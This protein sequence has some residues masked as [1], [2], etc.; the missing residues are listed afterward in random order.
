MR[1]SVRRMLCA[2]AIAGGFTVLGI[3][4]ATSSAS[5]ADAPNATSGANGLV[6]GN[7]TGGH[8]TAPV[9]ASDNQVTVIGD[10]NKSGGST[11]QGGSGDSSSSSG[12]SSS[13]NSTSGAGGNGSGNQTDAGATAPVD[14][15]DNQVTVIGDGNTNGS[16]T[17]GDN[18]GS[19]SSGGDTTSGSPGNGSGNQTD[20]QVNAPVHATGNQITAIGDGEVTD[21]QPGDNGVDPTAGPGSGTTGSESS[22]G[23]DGANSTDGQDGTGSGNQTDAG[24]T[25]PVDASGNQVTVIG[26]GNDNTASGDNSGST[27]GTDGSDTTSGTDGN[28]SGNQTDADAIAPVDATGNQVTVIGNGNGSEN[29]STE[30]TSA[31]SGSDSTTGDD[32]TVAGNQAG[33]GAVVPVDAGGNQVTVIGDGNTSTGETTAG[34]SSAGNGAG[35][36][37]SGTDGNG[38]GNQ[39]DAG[40]AA[41]VN[42]TGNQ[43]TVIGDGNTADNTTTEGD[44]TGSGDGNTTDGENGNGSGN[45]TDPAAS[46][47]VDAGDN[48]VTVIGDG[49][50]SET[51][52]ETGT[53]GSGG[54]TTD[55]Q[56][57]TGSG[58]QTAPGVEAPV[59]S[60]ENQITIIGDGNSTERDNESNSAE[61]ETDSDVPGDDPAGDTGADSNGDSTASGTGCRRVRYCLR[62]C[63]GW[64]LGRCRCGPA[65]D[66]SGPRTVALGRFRTGHPDAGPGARRQPASSAGRDPCRTGGAPGQLTGDVVGQRTGQLAGLVIRRSAAPGTRTSLPRWVPGDRRNGGAGEN[67]GFP[68]RRT[69][70]PQVTRGSG[71]RSAAS[72]RMAGSGASVRD[73][74][75]R[76]RGAQGGEVAE[77]GDLGVEDLGTATARDHDHL[78]VAECA[79]GDEQ[80]GVRVGYV[81]PV[82]VLEVGGPADVVGYLGRGGRGSVQDLGGVALAAYADGPVHDERRRDQVDEGVASQVRCRGHRLDHLEVAGEVGAGAVPGDPE[83]LDTVER[84]TRRNDAV[85]HHAR[86]RIE[87]DVVDRTALGPALDDLDRVDVAPRGTDGRGQTTQRTGDVGQ[88]DAEQVRHVT[89]LTKGCFRVIAK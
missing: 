46:A 40:A 88:C 43:V 50:T 64:S 48:Q 15:T 21:V 14:A 3:A 20:A 86:V 55:G 65:A 76:D 33:L 75:A 85:G 74:S 42:A 83:D 61:E 11:D 72:G 6:S 67:H 49:N 31:G 26:N 73:R 80:V 35:N 37:T 66:R 9:D 8:A 45:Q 57:G 22:E 25:A 59:D 19:A 24:A 56:D 2:T 79:A 63:A 52:D 4:F 71:V 10:N 47:P 29:N 28:G 54:D 41:P 39:T 36:T 12:P 38:S 30:G 51:A 81:D 60:S 84:R 70:D 53:D 82:A 23:S 16:A 34:E 32:G 18:A 77:P 62:A 78:V 17:S 5:A 27:A 1:T 68:L 58:N 69:S 7:Q 13:G 89:T 87:E 44:T